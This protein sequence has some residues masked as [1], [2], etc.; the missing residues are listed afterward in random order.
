MAI[1]SW[2][3]STAVSYPPHTEL[4]DQGFDFFKKVVLQNAGLCDPVTL[5]FEKSIIT[6]CAEAFSISIGA[7]MGP[8][9]VTAYVESVT[10]TS[11]TSF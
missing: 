8:S 5:N 11:G 10:G 3:R 7:L 9:P 2:P 6:Y 1:T 4:G